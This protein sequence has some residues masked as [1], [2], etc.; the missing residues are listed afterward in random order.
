MSLVEILP[1]MLLRK[2]LG[3]SVMKGE[4]W[5]VDELILVSSI[6][7]REIVILIEK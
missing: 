7:L 3:S 6:L 5:V 1:L 2:S 4:S